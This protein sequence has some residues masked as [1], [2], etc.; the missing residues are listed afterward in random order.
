MWYTVCL[1]AIPVACGA[2]AVVVVAVVVAPCVEVGVFCVLV[3][4]P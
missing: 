3:D 2:G 4:D 1:Q